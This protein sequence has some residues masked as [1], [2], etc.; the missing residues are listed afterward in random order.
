[1]L[2]RADKQESQKGKIQGGSVISEEEEKISL[3]SQR[4]REKSPTRMVFIILLMYNLNK[5]PQCC[6]LSGLG[7]RFELQAHEVWKAS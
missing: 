7:W 3:V 1:M 6:S 5:I 2:G 4:S